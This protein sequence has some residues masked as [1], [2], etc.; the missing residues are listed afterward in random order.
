MAQ[1]LTNIF[2]AAIKQG[3]IKAMEQCL[4]RV[5][6]LH[7]IESLLTDNN[8]DGESALTLILSQQDKT[9]LDFLLNYPKTQL[10]MRKFLM[11]ATLYS[12]DPDRFEKINS[13]I[14]FQRAIEKG[15][16][17]LVSKIL[18]KY[19]KTLECR[20]LDTDLFIN[21]CL[22]A[23]TESMDKILSLLVKK[24]CAV[25]KKLLPAVQDRMY[26]SGCCISS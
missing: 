21:L 8:N 11:A 10:V 22:E 9:I 26:L 16:Y 25:P 19:P 6:G 3:N 13:I 17:P 2:I 12:A 18:E 5:K 23:K 1:Q 4:E 14:M 20:A 7:N 24:G 15:D